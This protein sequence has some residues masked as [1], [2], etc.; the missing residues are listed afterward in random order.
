M[1]KK[2]NLKLAAVLSYITIII[3]SLYGILIIPYLISHLGTSEYGVYKIVTSFSGSLLTLDLGIN[4]TMIRFIA[5]YK[6]IKDEKGVSNFAA[7]GLI[8]C[9]AMVSVVLIV[10]AVLYMRLTPLYGDSLT[11]G[12]LT[13]LHQLFILMV[14]NV[15]ATMLSNALN[16]IIGGMNGFSFSQGVRA[17][18]MILRCVGMTLIATFWKNAIG[19]L[20]VDLIIVITMD[21]L[22]FSIIKTKYK[23]KIHLYYWDKEI[24]KEAGKF[25]GL[26]F[27]QSILNQFN[28][29]LDNMIIGA[30]IGTAAVSVYSIGLTLFNM[31]SSIATAL[32]GIML[33]TVTN[34]I[35]SGAGRKSLED[36]VIKLGRIQF[37]LLG[38]V[39]SGFWV[40]GKEFITLLYSAEY[41]TAWYICVILMTPALFYLIINVCLSILRAENKMGFQ[42][43]CFAITAGLNLAITYYGVKNFGI[44]AAAVGTAVSLVIVKLIAMTVYYIKFIKLDMIRIYRCILSRQWLC[45]VIAA[46]VTLC[47]NRVFVEYSWFHLI[48]KVAVYCV[49]YGSCQLLFGFNKS[50]KKML[51]CLPVISKFVSKAKRNK[52]D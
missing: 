22:Y 7:I 49:V 11:S 1:I 44:M 33:P 43:I 35:Y 46:A 31:F 14:I 51:F 18:R 13:R 30:L 6:A 45:V 42:T 36:T 29:N 38:A 25:T 8:I 5:K 39:L 27:I 47:M 20:A 23:L 28:G 4:G 3:D 15:A 10:A 41:I 24:F 19:I 16:G 2:D 9:G 52:K 37:C 50:E 26:S 40:V 12:E 48:V 34:Q 17:G 21:I 32:S